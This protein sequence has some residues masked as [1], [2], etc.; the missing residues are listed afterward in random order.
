MQNQLIEFIPPILYLIFLIVVILKIH[1]N[2]SSNESFFFASRGISRRA[3]LISIIATETSVA[4]VVIF[5]SVGYT[6]GLS[7]IWLC[8]GYIVGRFI[9]G[10][11]ILERIHRFEGLSLYAT[12]TEPKSRN[13]LSIVYLLAKYISGGVRFYLA[14][15][16]ID[17]LVGGSLLFWIIVVAVIVGLYSITGGLR[18]VVITDQIQGLII[19]ITGIWFCFVFWPDSWQSLAGI[20]LYSPIAGGQ[21]SILLF[22]G[23]FIITFSSHGADQDMLQRVFAVNDF[24]SARWSL[25]V[26]G[27]GASLVIVIFSLIGVFLSK[28]NITVDAA[29]PLV[30]YIATANPLS[31]GLFLV[32]VLAAS[33][34]TL[35]SAMHATGAILKDVSQ[36]LN[37]KIPIHQSSVRQYSFFSLL[38][39][40][41]AASLFIRIAQISYQGDFLG[42][43][44]GSMNYVNGGLIGI[45]FTFVITRT[46]CRKAPTIAAVITGAIATIIGE[47]LGLYWP[48]ITVLSAGSATFLALIL[49]R[50]SI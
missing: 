16:A 25:V 3:S 19:F 37:L 29:S 41:I 39:F 40:V 48:L 8:A 28:T 2:E 6:T 30:S 38:I 1:D 35:D 9:V 49:Q 42:L 23:G 11:Y 31:K 7:V 36:K 20:E 43:A 5:P 47:V 17:A 12:L 13:L 24:K 27:F 45:L 44:M 26:S 18:A 32:F 46:P 21:G 15:Y 22:L 50:K 14:A 33:M 34:S 4:T 10:Y